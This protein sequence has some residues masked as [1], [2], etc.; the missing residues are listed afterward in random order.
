[1]A[2][3]S[4]E[5]PDTVVPQARIRPSIFSTF[6]FAFVKFDGKDCLSK[7]FQRTSARAPA[8]GPG[9]LPPSQISTCM[10]N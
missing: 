1:M 6:R 2:H 5:M 4:R 7:T 10:Q 9:N 8:D 3:I